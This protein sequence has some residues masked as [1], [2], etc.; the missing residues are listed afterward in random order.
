MNLLNS[1]LFLL[2][3]LGFFWIIKADLFFMV[4]G[5]VVM[6]YFIIQSLFVDPL[7]VIFAIGQFILTNPFG[8][9]I[10]FIPLLL[11]GLD[12]RIRKMRNSREA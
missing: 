11:Y 7:S 12:Q 1:M 8:L 9:L 10:L 4:F 6:L 5:T 3:L 2:L